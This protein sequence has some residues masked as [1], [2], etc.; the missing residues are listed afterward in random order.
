MAEISGSR[1]TWKAR[2][3]Y[4]YHVVWCSDF[5]QEC[6]RTH[7]A[8][9]EEARITTGIDGPFL[10]RRMRRRSGILAAPSGETSSAPLRRP[11][12]TLMPTLAI[13]C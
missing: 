7:A 4:S 11:R 9:F 6:Q 10:D 5:V 2:G 13:F 1:E 3:T 12:P 8:L